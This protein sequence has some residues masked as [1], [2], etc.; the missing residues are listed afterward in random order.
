MPRKLSLK[1][2]LI[3]ASMLSAAPA[4]AW[5]QEAALEEVVVTAQKRSQ[6]LQDVPITIS[7]FTSEALQERA[8]GNVAQLSNLAPNVTLD[9]GTPFSGSPAVLSA[10]IRGIGSDD[11]AFNIDPGV[12]IYVDGVYLARTVG[13]NQDLL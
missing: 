12:G 5:S 9:G 4:V 11:F 7:A 13:A 2:L 10:F 1:S 3:A 6:N 8:V